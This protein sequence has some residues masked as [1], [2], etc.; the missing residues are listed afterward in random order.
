MNQPQ[1]TAG[2]VIIGDE[3]LS[4]RFEDQNSPFLIK[5][6]NA[7]GV[8]VRYCLTIPD[9]RDIIARIVHEY[10]GRVTWLFTSGGIGPTPDDITMESIALAFGVP[11]VEHGG[12]RRQIETVYGSL[13]TP[14]HLRM[15]RVPEGT[16]LLKTERPNIPVLQ[17]RNITIFPGVPEFLQTIFLLIKD[18]FRGVVNP[19][20]E[21]NLVTDEAAITAYLNQTLEAFPGLKLGSYPVYSRDEIRVKIV[22]EHSSGEL[23]N[24][25]KAFF[26]ERAERFIRQA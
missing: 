5:Q 1:T 12:I 13:C 18:R 2:I 10:A 16:Q 7:Q 17:F 6:L 26:E 25:A 22:M 4:G 11:L 3:I 14:E 19:V 9:D 8:S 20:A 15:A 24:Q 21:V 23:L